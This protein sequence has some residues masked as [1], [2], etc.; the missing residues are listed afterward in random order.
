MSE[1]LAVVAA[2]FAAMLVP[3]PRPELGRIRPGTAKVRHPHLV[4]GR[5]VAALATICV[6][7]GALLAGPVAAALGG[8]IAVIARW[9]RRVMLRSREAAQRRAGTADACRVLSVTLRAGRGP[10]DALATAATEQPDIA[11]ATRAAQIGGDVVSALREAGRK[12]GGEGWSAIAAA[13]LVSER[14]GASLADVV[15]QVLAVLRDRLAAAGE[16]QT[17]LAAVQTTAS[18]L[19]LLPAVPLMLGAGVGGDPVGFL[20]HTVAGGGCLA[21]GLLLSVAGLAWV[22]RLSRAALPVA[23]PA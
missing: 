1:P 19:A 9:R 12:P 14:S 5:S 17:E 16:A 11:A 8:C 10:A 4:G 13:W 20:F 3:A 15:D 6:A 23:G 21:V 22:D 18:L 7:F 2:A